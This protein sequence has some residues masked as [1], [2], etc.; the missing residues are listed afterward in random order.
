MVND[1]LKTT[2]ARTAPKREDNEKITPVLIEPIFLSAKRKNRIENAMLNAPTN[3]MYGIEINGILKLNPRRK[4]MLSKAKPPM[5]HFSPVTIMLSLFLLRC[6]LR[7]LSIPQ[8]KQAPII[9]KLP[10]RFSVKV[11]FW[12]AP[13]V[14][15]K[16]T[17]TSKSR[18]PKYSL[19]AQRSFK[20]INAITTVKSDSALSRRE[21]LIAVVWSRPFKSSNGAIIEPQIMTKASVL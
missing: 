10:R 18:I 12:N 9:S 8:K 16:I 19:F 7:L 2:K 13:F 11:S 14:V 20:K 6:L 21:E 15:T 1:S 17:P 3:K 5:K 4:D